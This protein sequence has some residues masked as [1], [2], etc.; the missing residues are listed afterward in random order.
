MYVPNEFGLITSEHT[1]IK[2]KHSIPFKEII[3]KVECHCYIIYL[4]IV[5]NPPPTPCIVIVP[6]VFFRSTYHNVTIAPA[7]YE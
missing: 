7:S 4:V 6:K 5:M 2:K 3:K 1:Q